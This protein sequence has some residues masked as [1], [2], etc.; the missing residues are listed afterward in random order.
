MNFV[1]HLFANP[2]KRDDPP[3]TNL[4]AASILFNQT[5]SDNGMA[6]NAAKLDIIGDAIPKVNK[7]LPAKNTPSF[8]ISPQECDFHFKSNICDS[9]MAIIIS[10]A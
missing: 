9:E 7:A 5:N 1:R 2:D 6:S 4:L 8:K 3:L 10:A